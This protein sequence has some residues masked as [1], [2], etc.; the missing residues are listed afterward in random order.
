ML[1]KVFALE[2]EGKL[3]EALLA[4]KGTN[5]ARWREAWA[6]AA[7]D[8][9]ERGGHRDR[10]DHR[11]LEAQAIG[12]KPMPHVA[13]AFYDKAREL[14]GRLSRRVN[15]FWA[16]QFGRDLHKQFQG[17][18]RERP[19]LLAEYVAN[20]RSYAREIMGDVREL[21]PAYSLDPGYE[22]E[23]DIDR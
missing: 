11:T 8:Y 4:A 13:H 15:A 1:R 23:R 18:E 21:E 19:D 6:G 10:I 5:L 16:A 7:N 2:R 12:R 9:L 14:T 20:A 3:D 22:R 17:M